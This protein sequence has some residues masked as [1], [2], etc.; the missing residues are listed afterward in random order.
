MKQS[1]I[2]RIQFWYD[3]FKIPQVEAIKGNK[4]H[5]VGTWI[6]PWYKLNKKNPP[7]PVF[8]EILD[9]FS[10]MYDEWDKAFKEAGNPYDLQLW[11]YDEHMMDSQLV[12]AGVEKDGDKKINYFHD[13]PEQY[14]FQSGKYKKSAYFDPDDFEWTTYEVRDYLYEKTDELSPKYIKK[15]LAMNWHEEKHCPET[16]LEE[17]CFWQI[18]DFVWVGRRK[19]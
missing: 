12:C 2:R 11:I 6:K 15:L 19:T 18:Y 1:H 7:L 4:D 17:R 16:D 10:R 5:Y 14:K 8:Q 9:A 13:C 3:L